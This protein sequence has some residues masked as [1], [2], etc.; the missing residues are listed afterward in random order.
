MVYHNTH[1]WDDILIV[2]YEINEK[3]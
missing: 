1:V 2:C 3:I